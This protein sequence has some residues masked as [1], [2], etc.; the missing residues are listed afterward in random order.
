MFGGS[1]DLMTC[2]P[3]LL[4]RLYT[5]A[6][7]SLLAL[8]PKGAPHAT[9]LQQGEGGRGGAV[10]CSLQ[11]DLHRKSSLCSV[12]KVARARVFIMP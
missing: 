2:L 10:W 5:A 4:M 7:S 3:G 12:S 1:Q 9:M 6:P 8:F 11:W